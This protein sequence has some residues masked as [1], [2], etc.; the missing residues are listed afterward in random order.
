MV[1]TYSWF[2]Y[3]KSSGPAFIRQNQVDPWIKDQLKITLLFTILPVQLTHLGRVMHIC[4]SKLTTIGSDN[5]LPPGRRQAIIWNNA[6]I[7]LTGPWRTNCS[8]ILIGIHAYSFKKMHLNMLFSKWRPFC[9]G[10][11]VLRNPVSCSRTCPMLSFR[12]ITVSKYLYHS[13]TL[14]LPAAEWHGGC[15]SQERLSTNGGSAHWAHQPRRG[16]TLQPTTSTTTG[17][18]SGR[19]TSTTTLHKASVTDTCGYFCF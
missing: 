12:T 9:L 3:L 14:I 19:H 18:I 1:Y 13:I 8:E 16:S 2:P 5:G 4:I 15:E 11:S 17:A 7:V 6:G 10:L